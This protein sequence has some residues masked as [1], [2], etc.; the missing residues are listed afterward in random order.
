MMKIYKV[1]YT[2]HGKSGE[3]RIEGTNSIPEAA[4]TAETILNTVYKLN[5]DICG[6]FEVYK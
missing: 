5:V 2:M 3:L 4:Q 6:V 1:K